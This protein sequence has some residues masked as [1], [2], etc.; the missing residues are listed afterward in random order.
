M[1]KK[2]PQE[3]SRWLR[4][5]R[6]NG[7]HNSTC[8]FAKMK[9][10]MN[11]VVN[12]CVVTASFLVGV[13]I[14]FLPESFHHR[15]SCTKRVMHLLSKIQIPSEVPK[16]TC[17]LEN[18]SVS[19][20]HDT[21]LDEIALIEQ[22]LAAASKDSAFFRLWC[23]ALAESNSGVLLN[24]VYPAIIGNG[25]ACSILL[26]VIAAAFPEKAIELALQQE[27]SH[28]REKCLEE[29]A[30]SLGVI[31]PQLATQIL[32]NLPNDMRD[33]FERSFVDSWSKVNP[34]EALNTAFIIRNSPA[35]AALD[36]RRTF[37]SNRSYRSAELDSKAGR[38][39]PAWPPQ[40]DRKAIVCGNCEELN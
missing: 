32:K 18:Y 29:I 10:R 3:A 5:W 21:D 30:I 24:A 26:S 15:S 2:E 34:K 17:W 7:G 22:A 9:T 11:S 16:V 33:S 39:R 38:E 28:V 35:R 12:V 13:A 27:S 37:C 23:E 20:P 19:I 25:D 36:G 6:K 31:S 40:R 14:G 1:A 4:G 8:R